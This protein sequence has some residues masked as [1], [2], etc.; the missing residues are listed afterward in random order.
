MTEET[1]PMFLR[2]YNK[3]QTIPQPITERV[4]AIK[5]FE[6]G[7]SSFEMMV[8]PKSGRKSGSKTVF[9]FLSLQIG[10]SFNVQSDHSEVTLRVNMNNAEKRNPGL[11]FRLIK[12][13]THFEIGRIN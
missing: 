6:V 9:P 11:K 8:P 2:A 7:N 5:Y 1:G 13:S 3:P 12:H 4:A 10:Q